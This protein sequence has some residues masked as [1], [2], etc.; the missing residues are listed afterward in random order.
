MQPF[1]SKTQGNLMVD[2]ATILVIDDEEAIRESLTDI[3]EYSGFQVLAAEDGKSGITLFEE[4]KPEIGLI[5][6]DLL[7]P[8]LSGPETL[9]QLRLLDPAVTILLSSGYHEDEIAQIL[10]GTSAGHSNI[11]FLQKPYSLATVVSITRSLLQ[12]A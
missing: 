1:Q 12:K 4:H 5:I 9:Q 10:D 2:Q 8:G 11:H 3:L 6:L 7:M